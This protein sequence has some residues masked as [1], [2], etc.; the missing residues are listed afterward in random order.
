MDQKQTT[1]ATT[2]TEQPPQNKTAAEAELGWLNIFYWR[3]IFGE[4]SAVVE[5]QNCLA[6]ISFRQ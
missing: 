2:T 6:W 5:T 1:T 4:G 3:Q